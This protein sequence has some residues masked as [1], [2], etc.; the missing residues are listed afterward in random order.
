[1]NTFMSLNPVNPVPMQMK[2][3]FKT[4]SPRLLWLPPGKAE[5]NLASYVYEKLK[6]QIWIANMLSIT[7]DKWFL[8]ACLREISCS[9]R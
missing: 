4:V 6:D 5:L 1:M 9:A 3:E 8:D 7:P 2:L